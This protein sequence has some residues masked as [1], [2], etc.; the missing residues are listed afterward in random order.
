[1][2]ES[3]TRPGRARG[4]RARLQ[5]GVLRKGQ[6][7]GSGV[8][9]LTRPPVWLKVLWLKVLLLFR[10]RDNKFFLRNA[11]RGKCHLPGGG[12]AATLSLFWLLR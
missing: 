10:L 3:R 1:M 7:E 11:G 8:A 5:R 12:H 9:F 4:V 6:A 2:R